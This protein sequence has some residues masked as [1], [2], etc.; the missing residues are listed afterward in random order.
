MH[1]RPQ[2]LHFTPEPE[3]LLEPW[4]SKTHRNT[5]KQHQPEDHDQSEQQHRNEGLIAQ[6]RRN[7]GLI[8]QHRWNEGWSLSIAATSSR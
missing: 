2:L 3:L 7:E 5:A 8:P 6:H 1:L 4:R